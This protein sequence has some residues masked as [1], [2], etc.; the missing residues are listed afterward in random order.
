MRAVRSTLLSDPRNCS[1]VVSI[2]DAERLE[3][4]VF[5]GSPS[6]TAA[7]VAT[8]SATPDG[9]AHVERR[10]DEHHDLPALRL[11]GRARAE[12]E[13]L[14][15]VAV[16]LGCL[17]SRGLRRLGRRVVRDCGGRRPVRCVRARCGR[18]DRSG[19]GADERREDEP[20]AR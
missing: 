5:Y 17:D 8:P 7:V 14:E 15:E 1:L 10:H 11:E 9:G 2:A 6:A 20:A 4:V 16:V 19:P 18:L 13:E 3:T 12:P